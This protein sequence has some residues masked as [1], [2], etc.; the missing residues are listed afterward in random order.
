MKHSSKLLFFIVFM[1][2]MVGAFGGVQTTARSVSV[3]DQVINPN[4]V[5]KQAESEENTAGSGNISPDAGTDFFDAIEIPMSKKGDI[6]RG[7]IEFELNAS[8]S[9]VFYKFDINETSPVRVTV[10][11]A[12][13]TTVDENTYDIYFDVFKSDSFDGWVGYRSTSEFDLP[14]SIDYPADTVGF[15]YMSVSANNIINF[16]FAPGE[17]VNLN[18]TIEHFKGGVARENE[19]SSVFKSDPI[20][21]ILAIQDYL[22]STQYIDYSSNGTN[23]KDLSTNDP[24]YA[25]AVGLSIYG[26]LK[27]ADILGKSNSDDT[28]FYQKTIAKYLEIA[29]NLYKS[30]EDAMLESSSGL[31]YYSPSESNPAGNDYVL[32]LADNVYMLMALGE[33]TWFAGQLDPSI[34]LS[35]DVNVLSSR[36]QGIAPR[37]DDMFSPASGDYREQLNITDY[38]EDGDPLSFTASD[39]ASIARSV[40][41][42][43]ES[44]SIL[45]EVYY[46]QTLT[47]EMDA[48]V[49]YVNNN[50]KIN[51]VSGISLL[52]GGVFASSYNT[53]TATRSNTVDLISNAFYVSHLNTYAKESYDTTQSINL[54]G[55]QLLAMVSN[56]MDNILRLFAVPGESSLLYSSVDI[57]DLTG[58]EKVISNIA[59]V[60]AIFAMNRLAVNW[61]VL[62]VGDVGNV[63]ARTWKMRSISGIGGLFQNLF[64]SN[65][66]FF[67]GYWDD[68]AK[69]Y[70]FNDKNIDKNLFLANTYVASVLVDMFP[71]EMTAIEQRDLA[72]GEEGQI[73]LVFNLL[74]SS[75]TWIWWDPFKPFSFDVKISIPAFEFEETQTIQSYNAFSLDGSL[76]TSVTYP[77]MKRGEYDISIE[78]STEGTVLL[79]QTIQSRALGNARAEFTRQS[80][81]V[82]DSSYVTDLSIIDETGNILSSLQVEAALGLSIEDSKAAYGQKY[83]KTGRT[84]SSGKLGLTFDVSDLSSD[85]LLNFTEIY[86]MDPIPQFVE[87]P[88]FINITNTESFDLEQRTII[89][90]VLVE[91]NRMNLRVSPTNLEITQGT[92]ETF[93]FT[94]TALDQD[95]NPIS[96][97]EVKYSFD[98][99]PVISNTVFT[100]ADGEATISLRDNDLIALN[101]LAILANEGSTGFD[102]R[103]INTTITMTVKSALYPEKV[104]KR[105]LTILPNS[106]IITANPVQLS[107]KEATIFDNAIPPI[108][109]EVAVNDI[110]S[111]VVNAFASIEW[112]DP[113]INKYAELDPT[114]KHITPYTFSVDVSKLPVGNYSLLITAEKDGITSTVDIK[115]ENNGLGLSQQFKDV[116]KPVVAVRNI[117]IEA[118]TTEDIALSMISVLGALLIAKLPGILSPLALKLLGLRRKC[119]H[120]DEWIST[121]NEVCSFCGRDVNTEGDSPDDDSPKNGGGSSGGSGG[122]PG[123]DSDQSIKSM[124]SFNTSKVADVSPIEDTHA[125]FTP[126]DN[127]GS[128]KGE[129]I[130]NE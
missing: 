91:L 3:T 111:K 110:F 52:P 43:F 24:D 114:E 95:Q 122:S 25:K 72:V 101:N 77:V 92:T 107:V 105:D 50:M 71:L 28:Q 109:V 123:I 125:N 93:T 112:R 11:S 127:M 67:F 27:S 88:L 65:N 89:V 64:D 61:E 39:Y 21:T 118:S 4:P 57:T 115:A 12:T 103:T 86:S 117:V 34:T 10:N 18:I 30:A 104:I 14:M 113:A 130:S 94:I 6:R 8:T 60:A 80:F 120:C 19:I 62:N 48:L 31:F 22:N 45:A 55:L 116:V 1:T 17:S 82:S 49:N 7:S 53:N 32:Y 40:D 9:F 23:L 58:G 83:I 20:N 13:G 36:L 33:I 44:Y 81:S 124:D 75:G 5:V 78:L 84:D 121:K 42:Q 38:A 29:Y 108:E 2:L 15:N 16:E 97:A 41:N 106:L 56:V 128:P 46:W 47:T 35:F 85:N 119:P 68:S 26:L 126:E 63:A 73:T 70:S 76:F 69:K 87:L 129:D 90:P 98:E 37:I 79:S 51:T 102:L 54:N 66:G 59:N 99:V 74:Q 100:D 96:N